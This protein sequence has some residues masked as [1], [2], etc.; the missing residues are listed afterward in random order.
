M[1]AS[2]SA[3]NS[4]ASTGGASCGSVEP[5][6]AGSE[7][8]PLSRSRQPPPPAAACPPAAC[9]AWAGRT[10]PMQTPEAS[11][12]PIR[13]AAWLY[14]VDVASEMATRDATAFRPALCGARSS[15]GSVRSW[16]REDAAGL[17]GLLRGAMC[18]GS[19]RA[20]MG[21]AL[22]SAACRV[23]RTPQPSCIH[24]CCCSTPACI[25]PLPTS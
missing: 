3:F 15:C 6:K 25:A 17:H 11:K 12:A 4:A 18:G 21:R 8:L 9:P 2:C 1:R 23:A 24:C 16:R 14:V 10:H 5:Q 13:C 20:H 7:G 19:R 22:I